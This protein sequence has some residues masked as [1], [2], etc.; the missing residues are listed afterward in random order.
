MTKIQKILYLAALLVT[1]LILYRYEKY[2]LYEGTPIEVLPVGIYHIIGYQCMESGVKYDFRKPINK[3]LITSRSMASF[4]TFNSGD[5]RQAKVTDKEM[6][7][8]FGYK[9]CFSLIRRKVELNGGGKFTLGGIQ[10]ERKPSDCSLKYEFQGKTYVD[11]Y[12]NEILL[13]LENNFRHEHS[14]FQKDEN[15]FLYEIAPDDHTDI[16]C[17][18]TDR[19]I[20][21]L[22]K[23]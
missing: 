22:Q 15:F 23:M 1:I 21:V 7:F 14:L 11:D 3:K 12:S 13:S 6:I 8:I 9:E 18:S 5:I 17:T 10:V 19:L 16:G 20:T 4:L 2:P